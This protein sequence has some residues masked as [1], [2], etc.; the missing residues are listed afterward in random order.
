MRR[1]YKSD[2]EDEHVLRLFSEAIRQSRTLYSPVSSNASVSSDRGQVQGIQAPASQPPRAA[3]GKDHGI[4]NE[5]TPRDSKGCG[6]APWLDIMREQ[7]NIWRESRE[8]QGAS[9]VRAMCRRARVAEEKIRSSA[10]AR[11]QRD[12]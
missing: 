10:I 12:A 2:E 1:R 9:C 7:R 8:Q 4:S 5:P 3:P 11:T 6:K